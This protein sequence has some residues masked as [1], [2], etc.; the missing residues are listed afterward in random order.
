MQNDNSSSGVFMRVIQSEF[1]RPLD[2]L[3]IGA[4]G[5]IAAASSVFASSSFLGVQGDVK[6][7]DLAS[8]KLAF[9]RLINEGGLWSLAF[10]PDGDH[11]LVG[12]DTALHVLQV[13][14]AERLFGLNLALSLPSFTVSATGR[15]LLVIER[16]NQTSRLACWDFA[17]D[18]EFRRLWV[19]EHHEPLSYSNPAISR[20][21]S[22]VA[23]AVRASFGPHDRSNEGIYVRDATDGK[24][25]T[26]IRW[27]ADDPVMELQFA[28]DGSLLLVRSW[29]RIVKVVDAVSG[30]LKGEL[31]H[32]GRAYITGMAV[33]PSGLLACSRNNGTVCFWNV[34]KRELVR[35]LD[36]KLGKLVSV[37]FSPDGCI[38]AAGTEDGQV[39]VWDMDE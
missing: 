16:V 32:R 10:T 22:R 37:A 3:A 19:D 4:R 15:R 9:S 6:V 13:S 33:H 8:G 39:I 28:A 34:E 26:S 30:H 29:G 31:I 23:V 38:G 5:H 7:W 35:V 2:L 25:Q 24:I 21:G 18:P 36:W 17:D 12:T 20:D 27:D 1:N 11:L 14:T